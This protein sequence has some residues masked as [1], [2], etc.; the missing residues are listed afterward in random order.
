MAVANG[1][2]KKFKK[3]KCEIGKSDRTVFETKTEVRVLEDVSRSAGGVCVRFPDEAAT[4]HHP[5]KRR[6]GAVANGSLGKF[7]KMATSPIRRFGH[8]TASPEMWKLNFRG[9]LRH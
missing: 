5:I 9:T 7:K 3:I 4:T 2:S 1:S 6:S 8:E